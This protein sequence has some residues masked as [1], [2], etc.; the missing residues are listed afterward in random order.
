MGTSKQKVALASMENSAYAKVH[1]QLLLQLK[2]DK[3]TNEKHCWKPLRPPF[4]GNICISL[5]ASDLELWATSIKNTSSTFCHPPNNEHWWRLESQYEPGNRRCPRRPPTPEPHQRDPTFRFEFANAQGNL[6]QPAQYPITPHTRRQ[7]SNSLVGA[8]TCTPIKGFHPRD[9]NGAGLQAFLSWMTN[10][11]EDEDYADLFPV[12]QDQK[13]G[14]DLFKKALHNSTQANKLEGRL[15][16]ANVKSG[17][18]DHLMMDF[19]S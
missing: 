6:I 15:E 1:K 16:K 17:M 14:I 9:Y 13:L 8:T 2:C 18:I 12:L 7:R 5:S 10:Y 11:Y 3:H 19:E 4:H